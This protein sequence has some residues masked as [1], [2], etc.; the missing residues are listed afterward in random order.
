ML[1]QGELGN[2]G[3]PEHPENGPPTKHPEHLG[4]LNR[5][6]IKQ[7]NISPLCAF[8]SNL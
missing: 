5:S 7:E 2:P 8:S 6:A 3:G 1:P 4:M